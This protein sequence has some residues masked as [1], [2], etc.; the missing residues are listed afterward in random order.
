MTEYIFICLPTDLIEM[1]IFENAK[2]IIKV[3]YSNNKE[4]F[5]TTLKLQIF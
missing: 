1:F 3:N 5:S 4:V 2:S